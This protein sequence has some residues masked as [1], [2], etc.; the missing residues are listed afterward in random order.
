MD[1]V[2]FLTRTCNESS[3]SDHLHAELVQTKFS[4]GTLH[5]D[6]HRLF[7]AANYCLV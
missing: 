1:F 5:L 7:L 3:S 6:N 2:Q 4:M